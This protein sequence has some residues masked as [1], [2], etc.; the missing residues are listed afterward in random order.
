[1][2]GISEIFEETQQGSVNHEVINYKG[3]VSVLSCITLY[4]PSLKCRL[5]SPQ[6]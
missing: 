1:M 3:E 2:T 6:Q 5:F 4:I